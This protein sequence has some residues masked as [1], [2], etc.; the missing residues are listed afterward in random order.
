MKWS[1]H[2][3]GF[4]P[5]PRLLSSCPS[6]QPL[7]Q[8][9]L[10]W[11]FFDWPVHFFTVSKPT[12]NEHENSHFSK[13]TRSSNELQKRMKQMAPSMI[14]ICV[15]SRTNCMFHILT[16]SGWREKSMQIAHIYL[17]DDVVE[18]VQWKLPAAHGVILILITQLYWNPCLNDHRL[19]LGSLT[20]LNSSG[21]NKFH[22]LID[23]N[24]CQNPAEHL[25]TDFPSRE[26]RVSPFKSNL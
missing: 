5:W 24:D 3:L 17:M 8:I 12:L 9:S 2:W 18:S 16:R 21:L 7:P 19:I 14:W 4:T 13:W 25:S 11:N 26:E 22:T 20:M 10:G 15:S 6:Y 23:V 1:L